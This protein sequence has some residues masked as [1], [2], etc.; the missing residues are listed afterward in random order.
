MDRPKLIILG[1]GRFALE[2]LDLILDSSNFEVVA[3]AESINREKCEGTLAGRPILWVDDLPPMANTHQALCAI[4]T[5]RR[6]TFTDQVTKMG[7]SFP[8]LCH[9]SATV[10]PSAEIG[11]GSIISLGVAI[12]SNTK[13]GQHTIVNRGSLI[14]H[15]TSVG[16][17][18][19]ISPGS[20]IAGEVT[21]GN[22]TFIG[23]GA[24]IMNG[25]TIGNNAVVG[26]GSVVN[27]DVP[28]NTMVLGYPAVIARE[29]IDGM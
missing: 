2:A 10:L 5:T 3:F 14:G 1:S 4:G 20:N 16:D 9:P 6:F 24:I 13:I 21:I 26:I 15:H 12:G 27:R 8:V 17:H 11:T 7:F 19:T 29:G 23:M 25:I 22:A 28:D 18:V